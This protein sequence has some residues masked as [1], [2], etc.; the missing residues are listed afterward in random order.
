MLSF[1][2]NGWIYIVPLRIQQRFLH[3]GPHDSTATALCIRILFRLS[4]SLIYI[5]S[6]LF[7][8]LALLDAI[9]ISTNDFVTL[10]EV[11]GLCVIPH[12]SL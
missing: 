7:L 9:V 11:E 2:L 4:I 12:A 3:Y 1:S 8:S 5:S 10:S 6:V